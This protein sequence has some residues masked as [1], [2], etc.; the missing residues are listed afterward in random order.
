M[1]SLDAQPFFTQ[2]IDVKERFRVGRRLALLGALATL[3]GTA[4]VAAFPALAARQGISHVTPQVLD[5]GLPKPNIPELTVDDRAKAISTATNNP[6]VVQILADRKYSIESVGV[7]HTS[8]GLQKIG[9]SVIH[10]LAQPADL[11][12]GWP[13]IEYD[14]TEITTPPYQQ[15]TRHYLAKGVK[16]LVVMVDLQRGQVVSVAPGPGASTP[17]R[18]TIE[19]VDQGTDELS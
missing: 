12:L 7:W 13:V 10:S 6:V 4:A 1:C 19:A 17:P 14:R 8:R 16:R 5:E 2:E 3:A 15:G 11:E 18:S 9:A